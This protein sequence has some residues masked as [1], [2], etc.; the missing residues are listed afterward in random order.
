MLAWE[1]GTMRHS[2]NI[3]ASAAYNSLWRY[4]KHQTSTVYDYDN[5]MI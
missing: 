2:E 4:K 3:I 1:I 5:D